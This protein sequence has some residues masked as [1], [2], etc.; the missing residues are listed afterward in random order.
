MTVW[1]VV[2]AAGDATRFGGLKQYERL[3]GRRVIDWSLDS[4]RAVCDGVVLVV[5]PALADR[6]EPGADVVVGGAA[7][8]PGSVRCGLEAVPP[9]AEVVV[10]HDA[11]RP[12]APASLFLSTVAAVRAGADG[13]VCAVPVDDTVKRVEDGEVRET[14]DR[15]GLWT[16][17]T[18]QAFSAAVLRDA[19]RGLPEGTD[20]AALVEAAGGRVV[21]VGGDARNLKLTRPGDLAVAQALLATL[22]S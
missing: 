17:Q 15:R 19:H 12:L 21:V 20:D 16:A 9:S 10:V 1:A 14:V 2:V 7:T 13:A 5:P 22:A 8:R 6:S 3:A 11:A 4:A 18:P